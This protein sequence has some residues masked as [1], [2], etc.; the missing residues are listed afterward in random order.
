MGTLTEP[1]ADQISLSSIVGLLNGKGDVKAG[2]E[3]LAGPL[4]SARNFIDGNIDYGVVGNGVVDDTA[5]LLAA[6]LAARTANRTLYVHGLVKFTPAT[7]AAQNANLTGLRMRFEGTLALT[8]NWTLPASIT[9]EGGGNIPAQFQMGSVGYI[10]GGDVFASANCELR[11]IEMPTQ[12]LRLDD[13]T[14]AGGTAAL[15]RFENV[16]VYAPTINTNP[17][18]FIRNWFWAWF[19]NCSFYSTKAVGHADDAQ[20]TVDMV[21]SPAGSGLNAL[22]LLYFQDCTLNGARMRATGANGASLTNQVKIINTTMENNVDSSCID[23]EGSWVSAN[24]WEIDQFI[25]ADQITALTAIVKNNTGVP[26]DGWKIRADPTSPLITGLHQNTLLEA[27][28]SNI[29]YTGYVKPVERIRSG[30]TADGQTTLTPTSQAYQRFVNEVMPFDTLYAYGGAYV[31][32]TAVSGPMG[33]SNGYPR[34]FDLSAGPQTD[35]LLIDAAANFAVLT[36]QYFLGGVW[37]YV[38]SGADLTNLNLFGLIAPVTGVNGVTIRELLTGQTSVAGAGGILTQNPGT[39]WGRRAGFWYYLP[40]GFFLLP[41]S[42][43]QVYGV[44]DR[45][46][47]TLRVPAGAIITAAYPYFGSL[48]PPVNFTDEDAI[49]LMRTVRFARIVPHGGASP[50]KFF[51]YGCAAADAF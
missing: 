3:A 16:S 23:I 31:G 7:I 19:K 39:F 42:A 30:F 40:V 45:L 12:T 22:Y 27:A 8:G 1:R 26:L 10:T 9:L 38:T 50:A 34:K 44:N 46:R 5:N 4:S 21:A 29:R 28:T 36:N 13:Q 35:E 33:E 49:Q 18:V 20:C 48:N 25:L 43:G 32:A 51:A 37:L 11:S 24:Q 15:A 47:L 41:A 17:A 14:F 6:M 2:L